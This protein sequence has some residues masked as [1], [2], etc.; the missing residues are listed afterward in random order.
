[1]AAALLLGACYG[2]DTNLTESGKGR[3]EVAVE[4][5]ASVEPGSTQTAFL[6]ITNPGPGD[7]DRLLVTFSL[8]GGV[9]NPIVGVGAKGENPNVVGI[10]PAPLK[11]SPDGIIYHFEGIE[12]GESTVIEFELTVPMTPGVVGNSVIVSD[13]QELDRARGVLLRTTVTR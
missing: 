7:I 2:S 6:D 1:M 11:V 9:D 13:A 5:P 4:F 3:P 8:R 10:Q 12:E